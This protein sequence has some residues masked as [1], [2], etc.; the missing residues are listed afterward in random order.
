MPELIAIVAAHADTVWRIA[1]RLLNNEQDALDCYQQT[2]LEAGV[3]KQLAVTAV[4]YCH[5]TD[6]INGHSTTSFGVSR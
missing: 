4:Q 2:F 5:P 1:V 6:H 3:S